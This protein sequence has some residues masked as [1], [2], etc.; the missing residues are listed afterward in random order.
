[1]AYPSD[2]ALNKEEEILYVCE[3]GKNRILRFILTPEGIPYFSVF[4]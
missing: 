4:T 2:L 3:T 1:L